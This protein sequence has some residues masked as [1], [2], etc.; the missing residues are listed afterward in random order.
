M[1]C[2]FCT[3][4]AIAILSTLFLG[5]GYVGILLFPE[6][7][8]LIIGID[9]SLRQN[10]ISTGIAERGFWWNFKLAALNLATFEAIFLA[11]GADRL[12]TFAAYSRVCGFLSLVVF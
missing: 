7:Q 4:V 5:I 9:C 3:I 2:K 1:L 11:D 10:L 8:D 12:K 6:G